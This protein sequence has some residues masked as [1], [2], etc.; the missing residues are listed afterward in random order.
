MHCR[1]LGRRGASR[2]SA[3]STTSAPRPRLGVPAH[4]HRAPL[5]ARASL[6]RR[7]RLHDGSPCWNNSMRRATRA[8]RW[9]R[10]L[11][12]GTVRALALDRRGA[13]QRGRSAAGAQ[14]KH[15]L[16]Q[17][18]CAKAGRSA[19]GGADPRPPELAGKAMVSKTLTAESTNEQTTA[20][21]TDCSPAEFA[22]IQQL[23]ADYNARFGWPFILAVRGPRG[24]GLT[25]AEIIATFARRLENHPDFEF[26]EA[27]ATSTASPRSAAERQVRRPPER[28]ATRCGTGPNAWPA[29]RPRACRAGPAHRHL[30]SPM[31]TRPAA[32]AA[33]AGCATA[34]STRCAI[35]AVGNVV[36][37]TTAA[38]RGRPPADRQPLRH[39]A[40]R[41]QV[42]R[43]AGHL[44]AAGG[45][46]RAAPRRQAPALRHRGG[47]LRRRRG[48]RY[49]ATFL[50]SGR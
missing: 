1:L 48:Q 44:R 45:G 3:S 32:R 7:H 28:W 41:R 33:A 25:R 15:A 38:D 4:R 46:A 5:E 47:R 35:D 8:S 37:S 12:D 36:A 40:Q 49:K 42:R 14:L 16:V 50:G 23:N 2:C 17:V 34:A 20:G 9:R 30:P 22:R 43:A 39:R 21:L 19:A 29:Q 26:A 27:C 10:A 13:L 6:R 24:T 18:L 31:R 11:L